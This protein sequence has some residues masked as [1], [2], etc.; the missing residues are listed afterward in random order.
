MPLQTSPE[1]PQPLSRVV[2]EVKAWVGR[3][4]SIWVD[5]QII[6]L[7]RRQ[8]P[9]QFLTLRDRHAEVSATVTCSAA[10]L[11]AAGPLAEG[12]Q[13]V[14]LVR[15]RVWEKSSALTFECHDI[16]VR[17]EGRLLA[18]LEQRKRMLQAE[19][20]FDARRKKPLPF[21]P[22]L[23]G[24]IAGQGS[25]AERDVRTHVL[26]RWPAAQ[27]R[28]VPSLVQGPS[29]AESIMTALRQLDA[30]RGVEVIV[31]ARGG[32]SLEDLLPFS[33]EGVVR[34]I[35][36]CRTPVVTAIGHEADTPIADLAADQRAST[37]TD[38]AKYLVPDA[39]AEAELMQRG[40]ERIRSAI[41]Q[42]IEALSRDLADVRSRPA[43]RDPIAAFAAHDER[44]AHLRLRLSHGIGRLLADEQLRLSHALT[45]VRA[46][47]PKATLE[48]GYAILTTASGETVSSAT[49][50]DPG[51][52]LHARLGH[53]QLDLQV[54]ASSAPEDAPL[55]H[56][57]P[58]IDLS[59]SQT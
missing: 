21:L 52:R 59:R 13:V 2:G 40:L 9:T 57:P 27:I 17:G 16:R 22:R 38:A 49:Q 18:E 43:L 28:F 46:M 29:A 6:E 3:L 8:G 36:A 55:T 15:P 5:A 30:D 26:R 11:D 12:A 51:D 39:S 33:N 44:L 10:V 54:T 14:A 4:G 24:L 1:Q 41:A 56:R 50:A 37:P 23:I 53:G 25:D 48:R 47:S 19:G 34:A 20:L 45:S 32:G 7:R 31:L 58:H 35:A 42:R